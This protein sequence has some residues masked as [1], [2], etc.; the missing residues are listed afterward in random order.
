[1]EQDGLTQGLRA[2]ARGADAQVEQLVLRAGV[3]SRCLDDF[4]TCRIPGTEVHLSMSRRLFASC[5][6]LHQGDL[7]IARRT[8][9]LRAKEQQPDTEHISEAD[10]EDQRLTRRRILHEQQE[11]ACPRLRPLL[12]DAYEQGSTSEWSDLLHRHQEP[13]LELR[14]DDD[15]LEAATPETY[16]AVSRHN[17]PPSR[18]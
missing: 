8:S 11:E 17:L 2:D 5:E 1:M 7:L 12:R 4:L 18:T 15:L 9:G 13:Q 16:L 10:Q 6:R 3:S 14:G